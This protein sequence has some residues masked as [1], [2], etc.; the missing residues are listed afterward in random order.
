MIKGNAQE[1]EEEEEEWRSEVRCGLRNKSQNKY[2]GG[3]G[4]C[5]DKGKGYQREKRV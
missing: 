2:Q 1:R 3:R 4:W 5:K